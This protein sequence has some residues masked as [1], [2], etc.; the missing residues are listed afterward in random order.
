MQDRGWLGTSVTGVVGQADPDARAGTTSPVAARPAATIMVLRDGGHPV[1]PLEV[2]MLRR[3]VRSQLAGGA[4]VFPGG[5]VDA[6]DADAAPWCEGIDDSRAS[7]ALRLVSGGLA[8]WVA[9]VRECFEEAGLL[10]ARS[11]RGGELLALDDPVLAARVRA[12]RG[13]LNAR[14]RSFCEVCAA[15]GIVLALDHLQYFAHWI[16]PKGAPRRYDT[17]FFVTAAPERQVPAHDAGETVADVWLRPAGAL[18][19]HRSGKISLMLPTIR[20]LQALEQFE[21][22]A[23][24][25]EAASRLE[26][27]PAIEPRLAVGEDGMTLLLPGDPG[28]DDA[29]S[30]GYA[31]TIGSGGYAGA[32]GPQF[33][34]AARHASRRANDS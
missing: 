26:D 32:I 30:G 5:A 13:E 25:L 3:N 19:A 23:E 4:H 22:A 10:L 15:E 28:Y 31:G 29:G 17:R 18:E 6:E 27:V 24:A 9:A 7:A 12:H 21:T 1:A 14:R 16:T 11:C 33:D 20:V 8:Y 2:L 34:A